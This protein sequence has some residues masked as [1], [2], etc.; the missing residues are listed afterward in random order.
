M[1]ET[2]ATTQDT[3]SKD[4]SAGEGG[5][6][7][8]ETPQTYTKQQM[9]KAVSDALSQAGRDAKALET[10]RNELTQQAEAIETTKQE[11]EKYRQDQ[12]AAFMEAVK[13]NPDAVNWAEKNKELQAKEKELKK[14]LADFNKTKLEYDAQIKAAQETQKEI[15]IFSVASEKKVDPQRL[16]TLSDK[17]GITDKDKLAELADEIASK[18]GTSTQDVHIDSGMTKG[19]PGEKSEEQRLKDRYPSMYKK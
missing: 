9:D 8:Q 16:K 11:I 7:S 3:P 5:T 1:D 19:A 4:S 14:Q 2:S 17:F 15:N 6:T 10:Q 13:N 12:D 18:G